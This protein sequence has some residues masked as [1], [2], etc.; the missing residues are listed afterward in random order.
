MDKEKAKFILESFRPDGADAQ[1]PEF[2]EALALA[3]EDR[4]LGEWL[5]RERAADAAFAAML[6]EVEIPEDLR[7]SIFSV[8]MGGGAGHELTEMDATMAG[9]LSSI[10]APEGLRAQILSAMEVES[11]DVVAMPRQAPR[12]VS[13]W[14][15]SAAIAAAVVLGAFVALKV[16][17]GAPGTL[18]VAKVETAAINILEAGFS[19]DQRNAQKTALVDWLANNELPAPEVFPAG[20]EDVPSVG[21]KELK[22][23]GK[24][25]S[26]ICFMME[27]GVV[28]L[29][30]FN[31]EDLRGELPSLEDK[32]CRG[33]QKSGWALASWSDEERGFFLFGQMAPEQLSKAF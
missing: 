20:L 8:L 16:P 11:G 32:E 3:V 6:G 10:R 4:E 1:E 24:T 19:L 2:A 9:A 5:A 13:R 22:I 18:A 12:R 17:A 15:A 29:M 14:L 27:E 28:H 25:A 31:L 21:C 33:C 23:N 30:V 7:E 26:L